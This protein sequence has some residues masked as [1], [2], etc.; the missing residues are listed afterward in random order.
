MKTELGRKVRDR[1]FCKVRELSRKPF[2]GPTR[3]SVQRLHRHFVLAKK[4]GIASSR[5]QAYRFN[6]V[7]QF[8]RIVLR[9]LPEVGVEA[10]EQKAGTV[11][12]APFQV[13]GKFFQALNTLSDLRKPSAL[14]QVVLDSQAFQAR[15]RSKLRM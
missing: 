10:L 7:K 3:V 4:I 15:Q 1:F 14:H 11:V 13:V 12:P 9:I 6:V 8:Y 5:H 2:V